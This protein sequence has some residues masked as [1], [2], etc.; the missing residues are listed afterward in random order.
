MFGWRNWILTKFYQN[1]C[2]KARYG[3]P[4]F[5]GLYAGFSK[6]RSHKNY[7]IL[8]G[9]YAVSS[10]RQKKTLKF[11]TN[12]SKFFLQYPVYGTDFWEGFSRNHLQESL[13]GFSLKGQKVESQ[14]VGRQKLESQK[15][16]VGLLVD[17]K[18]WKYEKTCVVMIKHLYSILSIGN[19]W[20]ISEIFQA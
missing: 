8:K 19:S 12:F 10:I 20:S 11:L 2:D 3:K 13:L 16:S 1:L 5:T 6:D 14:N 4:N 17:L 7:T 15:S 9:I 18:Y